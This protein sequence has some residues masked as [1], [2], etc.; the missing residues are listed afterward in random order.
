MD[1]LKNSI[2]YLTFT[3][4]LFIATNTN[5]QESHIYS[6]FKVNDDTYI[7]YDS[8]SYHNKLTKKLSFSLIN[9]FQETKVDQ[10]ITDKINVKQ[11]TGLKLKY[12]QNS[13][14]QLSSSL[15]SNLNYDNKDEYKTQ[16]FNL[17][18]YYRPSKYLNTNSSL[19]TI[20]G[21][22][23]GKKSSGLKY[24][25]SADG[26]YKIKTDSIVNYRLGVD[27]NNLDWSTNNLTY[28]LTYNKK[29]LE[30]STL[31][32]MYSRND[33]FEE[34]LNEQDTSFYSKKTATQN[35]S[36]NSEYKVSPMTKLKFSGR[37]NN[38][39]SIT[40]NE[41]KSD[42]VDY[43][44]NNFTIE[45]KF[46][47]GEYK[48]YNLTGD[49]SYSWSDKLYKNAERN[50]NRNRLKV[51]YNVYIKK[52]IL[53]PLK[54]GGTFTKA[55]HFDVGSVEKG[56]E[57]GD[58]D[59][60]DRTVTVNMNYPIINRPA[61]RGSLMVE[62]SVTDVYFIDETKSIGSNRSELYKMT[63]GIS[64]DII[65]N[66]NINQKY[67]LST[68]YLQNIIEDLYN[69]D[70]INLTDKIFR[71]YKLKNNLFYILGPGEKID[72][73]Y[74][75][76]L[77]NNGI[78]EGGVYDS[79]FIM[80]TNQDRLIQNITLKGMI[81][82]FGK[83]RLMPSYG[84]RISENVRYSTRN[85]ENRRKFKNISYSLYVNYMLYNKLK[86]VLTLNH[87]VRKR[88]N[89]T[90]RRVNHMNLSLNLPLL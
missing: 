68:K 51:H 67:E 44:S 78:L 1:K 77:V 13:K 26:I 12:R 63:S 66:L 54:I 53:N 34:K 50:E 55:H 16:S 40:D 71:T 33:I 74:N 29:D 64:Y 47:K 9:E 46:I 24:N 27:G 84:Y 70:Y 52:G 87:N 20:K 19:G 85:K 39:I 57:H 79:V 82:I 88:E 28:N 75:L 72:L 4:Y 7:N 18:S 58:N 37:Y 21:S 48:N 80:S 81:K 65:D 15:N 76:E 35:V 45:S 22:I 11:S 5:S 32:I 17:N 59:R 6:N 60:D 42:L 43:E 8:L 2:K 69:T 49:V 14:L 56:E 83:L 3:I 30:N 23:L 90:P 61:L 31:N 10:G 36:L 25:L 41:A 89:D 73:I 62:Y 38:Y 86:A